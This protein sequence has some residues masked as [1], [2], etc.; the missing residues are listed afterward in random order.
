MSSISRTNCLATYDGNG[1][2]TSLINAMDKSLAAR[3]KYNPYGRLLRVTGSLARQNSFR[4]ATKFCDNETGLVFYNYRFYSP[5]PG[6]RC[7][8]GTVFESCR[9]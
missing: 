1:N 4:F 2:I 3:Y 7:G 8:C 6:H 5:A 9:W